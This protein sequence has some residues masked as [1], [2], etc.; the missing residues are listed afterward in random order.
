MSTLYLGLDPS[1]F[2]TRNRLVHVPLIRTVKR[3]FSHGEIG[4]VFHDLPS[5]THIVFL[6]R[7][8]VRYFFACAALYGGMEKVGAEIIAIG[9]GTAA[10]LRTYVNRPFE[11]AASATQEGVIATLAKKRLRYVLVP[12]SARSRPDLTAFL[13]RTGVR[14]QVCFLYDTYPLKPKEEINISAFDEIVFT[15]PSVVDAFCRF[16]GPLP[17]EDRSVPIGPVTKNVMDLYRK[18]GV[19]PA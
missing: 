6:S 1:R 7:R 14:H 10:L 2:V 17:P 19:L 8:G 11:V 9:E 18:G 13:V 16:F 4:A 12:C 15:G 3:D 5:Y